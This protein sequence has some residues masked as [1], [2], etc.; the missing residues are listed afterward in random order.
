MMRTS[1]FLAFGGDI[2]LPF[3]L[4]IGLTICL[5]RV[6]FGLTIIGVGFW[7]LASGVALRTRI[8]I[9]ISS[10]EITDLDDGGSFLESDSW[11]LSNIDFCPLSG[12]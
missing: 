8:W 4:S 3:T 6:C 11:T 9:L 12:K 7:Y 2:V 5:A 1:R 10:S